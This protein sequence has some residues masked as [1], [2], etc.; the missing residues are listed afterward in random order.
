[1][2]DRQVAPMAR[3]PSIFDRRELLRHCRESSQA[4]AGPFPH[5]QETHRRFFRGFL[6]RIAIE[7]DWGVTERGGMHSLE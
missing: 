7:P 4:I 6:Y 5:R 1:M 3:I 2:R